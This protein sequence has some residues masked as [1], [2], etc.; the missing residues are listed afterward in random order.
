MRTLIA[1]LV[2]LLVVM[3]GNCFA[4]TGNSSQ[5]FVLFRGG[6]TGTAAN[7]TILATDAPSA[8]IDTRYATM[9]TFDIYCDSAAGTNPACYPQI[10]VSTDAITWDTLNLCPDSIEV[11]TDHIIINLY[12]APIAASILGDVVLPVDSAF[13]S[14]SVYMSASA[15]SGRP[16]LLNW[17]KLFHHETVAG[18]TFGL[19]S[20]ATVW[21]TRRVGYGRTSLY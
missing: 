19:K 6:D 8:V 5:T 13:Q 7:D 20:Y 1:C 18:S 11:E 10:L 14:T 17:A 12:R 3:T 9:V 2:T 4:Q 21:G 15:A 16:Q